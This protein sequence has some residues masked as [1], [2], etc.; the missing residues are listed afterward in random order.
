MKTIESNNYGEHNNSPTNIA[1]QEHTENTR[2]KVNNAIISKGL[3]EL[4]GIE[5]HEITKLSNTDNEINEN[6]YELSKIFGK[7]KEMIDLSLRLQKK[8]PLTIANVLKHYDIYEN[9]LQAA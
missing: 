8:E 2:E 5:K 9:L 3:S 4:F 1:I 7:R 6:E